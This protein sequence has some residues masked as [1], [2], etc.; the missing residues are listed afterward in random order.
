MRTYRTFTNTRILSRN[1]S[2][3]KISGV[4]ELLIQPIAE[5]ASLSLLPNDEVPAFLAQ[6]VAM[7]GGVPILPRK[8]RRR[9]RGFLRCE[10]TREPLRFS[11][12]GERY[13][14]CHTP[15]ALSYLSKGSGQHR[16]PAP[17]RG[18][19]NTQ[20]SDSGGGE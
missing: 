6:R 9:L 14:P 3:S 10:R 12:G 5:V 2:S 16:I 8:R 11:A 19:P 1:G 18:A 20:D 15:D 17:R 4:Q 13:F 7:T